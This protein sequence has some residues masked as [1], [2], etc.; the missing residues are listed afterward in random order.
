MSL[1]KQGEAEVCEGGV[2][3]KF[4]TDAEC[5]EM[6]QL[7]INKRDSLKD[8][9]IPAHMAMFYATWDEIYAEI[10]DGRRWY[11]VQPASSLFRRTPVAVMN[12]S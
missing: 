3:M 10:N 5:D 2:R 6:N 7:W 1:V 8:L 11:G 12:F 4:C 9:A